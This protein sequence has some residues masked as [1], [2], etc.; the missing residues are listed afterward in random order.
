MSA[1]VRLV[2]TED[3]TPAE[4]AAL[5]AICDEAFRERDAPRAS[6]GLGF[7]DEDWDHACGGVHAI[8]V[9]AG[10][11]VAHA[12][13]V[14]RELRM[15]GV[16][17]R[18]GYVEA[19]ATHPER[20]RGGLGTAVMRA[21]GE[22]IR[23]RFPLGALDTSRHGFYERL[24][25]ERWRGPTFVRIGRGLVPTPEEDGYVMVLRTPST[26]VLDLGAPISCD[27]RDGDVW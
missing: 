20:Q 24:G 10:V 5:R 4:L 21:L 9:E 15:D 2:P 22:H 6:R 25:W 14:E 7:T 27:W 26:P 19:V 11:A 18:A 13:V 16:P 12:S 3:L 1:H 17:I 23:E 8:A